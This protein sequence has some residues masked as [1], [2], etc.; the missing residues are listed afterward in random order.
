[1]VRGGGKDPLEDMANQ[2]KVCFL[3]CTVELAPD[4]TI[5]DGRFERK[6]LEPEKWR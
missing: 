6:V 1:M 2:C 3:G 4:V 5:V